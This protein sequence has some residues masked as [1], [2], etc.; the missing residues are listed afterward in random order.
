[1]HFNKIWVLSILI[2]S[3]TILA[4]VVFLFWYLRPDDEQPT[5][6]GETEPGTPIGA[7]VAEEIPLN[8]EYQDVIP[9]RT[10][11]TAIVV[12]TSTL[13][14]KITQ[15]TDGVY[16]QTS[17]ATPP[18]TPSKTPTQP[19]TST[20]SPSFTWTPSPTASNTPIPTSTPYL[21]PTWTTLPT[22]TSTPLPTPTEIPLPTNTWT[23]V[24]ARLSGRLLLN[25]IPIEENAYLILEDQS[26]AQI[27]ETIVSQDGIYTFYDVPTNLDGYNILFSQD[28]NNDYGV[29]DVVSWGWLGPIPAQEGSVIDLPDFDV[30]LQGLEYLNPIPDSQI[31]G[32]AITEN[33]PL[34][35]QWTGHPY[36]ETYWVT[37]LD[38]DNFVEIWKSGVMTNPSVDFDGRLNNNSI[39]Q[40]GQYWWVVGFKGTLGDFTITAFGFLDG[41]T[42]I[43]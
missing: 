21:S 32:S 41:F 35:F 20:P 16:T 12:A 37:L 11:T 15:I 38:G 13:E 40:P 7:L 24:P 31:S 5:N 3:T 39:I 22:A 26:L 30:G 29:Y 8:Q 10:I 34:S 23:P 4:G 27:A 36:A 1:L 33:S 14:T 43:P 9:T 18:G 6:P 42:V 19:P 28:Q 17:S 2:L 25:G